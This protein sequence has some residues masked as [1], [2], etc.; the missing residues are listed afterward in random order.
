MRIA[1]GMLV[2]LCVATSCA[3]QKI[4]V[5]VPPPTTANP[6]EAPQTDSVGE[7]VRADSRR[8]VAVFAIGTPLDKELARTLT[9]GV[10]S[11]SRVIRGQS[12]IQ[13]DVT[14][15]HGNSGGPSA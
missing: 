15:N 5:A 11:A 10:V 3:A 13:S 8:D 7:V 1:L 14:V 4:D 12:W 9:R 6:I 2:A